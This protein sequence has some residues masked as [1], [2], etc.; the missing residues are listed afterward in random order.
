MKSITTA[1]LCLVAML[2]VS[3]VA[4]GTASAVGPTWKSCREGGPNTKYTEEECTTASGTGKWGWEEVKGTEGLISIGTLRL[5]DTNIL[6]KKVA[7]SCTGE[8]EGSVGPGAFSRVETIKNIKCKAGENCEKITKEPEPRNLPWQGDIVETEKE[9]RN[10]IT[11]A[12]GE[13]AG[14]AVTCEVLKFSETDTC[15]I[16]TGYTTVSNLFTPYHGTTQ[17]VWLQLLDYVAAAPHA[18]CS[19]GGA[20]AGVV[21]GSTGDLMIL[22]RGGLLVRIA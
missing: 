20:G 4:A 3:M 11:S 19:I 15:T 1:G 17:N 16:N 14:W 12:N 13:G 7:V 2:L 10:Y 8:G 22:N 9:T 21:L 5:E 18:K 6:G